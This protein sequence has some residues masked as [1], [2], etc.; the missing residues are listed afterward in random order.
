MPAFLVTILSI[1]G[2]VVQDLPMVEKLI[3]GFGTFVASELS[4]LFGS[5]AASTMN[6]IVAQAET[7]INMLDSVATDVEAELAQI[8]PTVQ[9][10]FAAFPG[11]AQSLSLRSAIIA[12]NPGVSHGVAAKVVEA[13]HA[14]VRSASSAVAPPPA[15]AQP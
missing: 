11:L 5:T 7:G 13:A 12:D 2:L 3:A 9:S 8:Y 14:N 4:K 6:G 1:L 15:P 10:L